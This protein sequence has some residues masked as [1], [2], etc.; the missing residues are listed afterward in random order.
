LP[1]SLSRQGL[2]ACTKSTILLPL[3]PTIPSQQ[4][5][6]LSHLYPKPSPYKRSREGVLWDTLS[7]CA[8]SYACMSA[9]QDW[10]VRPYNSVCSDRTNSGQ[11]LT[12]I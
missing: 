7:L 10:E 5:Q 8:S 9:R 1:H 12:S 3:T 6:H 11:S 2:Q 4:F